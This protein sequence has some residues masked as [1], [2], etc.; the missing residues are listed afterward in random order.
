MWGWNDTEEFLFD[1]KISQNQDGGDDPGR[2][3]IH[4]S[5]ERRR[6]S[7]GWPVKIAQL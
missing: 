2:G 1:R 4:N 6:I 3:R 5:T 7:A